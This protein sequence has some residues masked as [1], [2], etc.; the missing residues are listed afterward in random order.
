MGKGARGPATLNETWVETENE[1]AMTNDAQ[2]NT[3]YLQRLLA[4]IVESCD[5]AIV[6]ADTNGV[7]TTWNE[8]AERLY[9]HS[10]EEAI[11]KSLTELT[12]PQ[13]RAK[14]S[15][16][17]QQVLQTGQVARYESARESA[18]HVVVSP[19]KDA[20]G[21]VIGVSEIA[22]DITETLRAQSVAQDSDERLRVLTDAVP[23]LI[24]TNDS[25]GRADYFNQR[26][27]AY[28]GLT[29][30]QSAGLGWQAMVHPDDATSSIRQWNEAFAAGQI[31][32]TEYRLRRADGSY[33]WFLGRNVPVPGKDG[34]IR[35]WYGTATDID[36]LKQ[37]VVTQR[38]SEE[39]LRLIVEN[40]REYAIFSMDP[41]RTV[42]TWNSGAEAI[43][44]FS[45]HEM[46]GR[47]GDIIFVPE[48]R[49]KHAP[50]REAATAL[51]DG[52]AENERWH[53]RND[54]TRFWGS[55]MMM[56]MCDDQGDV[57]G[58][59]KILRDQTAE[60]RAKEELEASH[61]AL[62]ASLQDAERARAEAEAAGKAKDRFLAVLSHEL[63]TPLAPL[64]IAIRSLLRLR[65]LPSAAVETLEMIER[66]VK[67]ETA[68]VNELLDV[69][70]ITHGKL[71]LY[72]EE[73]DL[74][75]VIKRAVEISQSDFESKEQ[76]LRVTLEAAHGQVQGDSKR[77]QQVFWNLLKNAAKFTPAKGAISI[78]TRNEPGVVVVEVA[79]TGIGFEPGLREQIFTP[80]EQGSGM[81]TREFGGL[82]LGLAIAKATLTPHGGTVE[83]ASPGPGK[84]AI[85]TVRLPLRGVANG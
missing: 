33:R 61:K 28:S 4:S 55:G 74:H 32:E 76:E 17:I 49:A 54:G 37:V 38:A 82:G 3:A 65:D 45:E 59:L 8:A 50:E 42:T 29:F 46:I 67:L 21:K 40:A 53:L 15:A 2:G 34:A 39:R 47:S 43:L 69:T 62:Q 27:Y 52:R 83:A 23:Q 78:R 44:G 36:D 35:C 13:N 77:L 48:D 41:D 51:K 5:D 85:F 25:T 60:L 75:D 10:P 30:E 31:F 26:W 18:L 7:V 70:S 71:E 72:L 19:L 9:G 57:I 79:D 14:L 81:V 58:L 80:F 24:W 11:G 22:R 56:A 63:R 20:T 68:L 1:L 64:L 6:T 73:L 84:G 66:N 16:A 12:L